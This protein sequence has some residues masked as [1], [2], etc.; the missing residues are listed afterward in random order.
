MT[1][2]K[3]L[4][5]A[6]LDAAL[7]EQ[8]EQL[9]Q[10]TV[11]VLQLLTGT[12]VGYA[13]V[14]SRLSSRLGFATAANCAFLFVWFSL[15]GFLLARRRVSRALRVANVVI[16]GTL[17]WQ[18][19][20]AISVSEGAVYAL[21]SWVP[22]MMFCVLVL[23]HCARLNARG[24][25]AL[26]VAGGV[27]YLLAYFVVA[28][29]RIPASSASWIL[30]QPAMQAGR[31]SGLLMSGFLGAMVAQALLRAIGRAERDVRARDLF[32]KY[33]LDAR[34]AAGGMGVV[35]S[36]IYC[37]EGGFE[38]RVAVKRVHDHLARLPS[39]VQAFREEAELSAR[40]AHPNVVQ[41]LDFGRI[42]EGYFLAMEFVDGLTL[43]ALMSHAER[44][45]VRLS[46]AIVGHILR[47]VLTGLEY[48]HVGAR[49]ADGR[50]LRVVHR[51]LCPQNVLISRNGEVKLTDFGIAR[52]LSDHGQSV[53]KT[54]AGH[55]GYMAPEQARAERFDERADLFPV[56]VMAWEMLA[57]RPLFRRENDV[58]SLLSL[59]HDKVVPIAVHRP[60]IDARWSDLIAVTLERDPEQRV[61]SARALQTLLDELRDARVARTAEE[62]AAMVSR[63]RELPTS[64]DARDEESTRVAR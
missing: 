55:V 23:A 28:M 11:R 63:L 32:G 42:E 13:L 38:R 14:I 40:L 30:T 41:V 3:P 27:S 52:T 43:S 21:S 58:A 51:D 10:I 36:A 34:I 50:P 18:F 24:S 62:L 2:G 8:L 45:G 16:E 56:G 44:A 15:Y 26:G 6:P 61:S 20:I 35:Y 48:A 60:D 29:P 39:F 22:P 46:P 37:P 12:G 4:L 47:E 54:V 31:A 25:L 59:L 53:T 19:F 9:E 1:A 17:P 57:L 5:R 7:A 64:G 33:R 49:G